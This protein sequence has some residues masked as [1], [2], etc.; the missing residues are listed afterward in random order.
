VGRVA[1]L[2]PLANNMNTFDRILWRLNGILI[3]IGVLGALVLITYIFTQSSQFSTRQKQEAAVITSDEKQGKQYLQL[4]GGSLIFGNGILRFPLSEIESGGS[5]SSSG[6]GG[7]TRNYL[8]LNPID[9]KSWWL[10][11]DHKSI[12]RESHDLCNPQLG[13]SKKVVSTIY[14]IIAKD[15]NGDGKISQDDSTRAYFSTN[16]NDSGKELTGD[17]VRIISVQQINESQAIVLFQTQTE[18]R[19][20]IILI[21]NGATISE[22][23]IPLKQ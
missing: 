15:T 14:E 21:E 20:K 7:F 8:F 6:Y 5:F 9:L 19:Y 22:T 2:Y 4:G 18:T 17:S 23:V 11:P 1:E 12:I 3:L 13:A 10:L 16:L